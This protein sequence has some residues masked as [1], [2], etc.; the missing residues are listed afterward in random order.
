MAGLYQESSGNVS[1]I[2]NDGY[3][4]IVGKN[5]A[6]S[7]P[8][9]T[10]LVSGNPSTSIATYTKIGKASIDPSLFTT[11]DS[12]TFE[13]WFETS[14][15]ANAAS[16]RLFNYTDNVTV[17]DATLTTVS[18]TGSHQTVTITLPSSNKEY[19]VHLKLDSSDPSQLAVCH[20]ATVTIYKKELG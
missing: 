20:R 8:Q 17:T 4:I 2:N 15:I 11:V 3:S 19:E 7:Y 5:S 1:Y 6:T 16:V 9:T 12:I 14:S 18:T 13:A 10:V